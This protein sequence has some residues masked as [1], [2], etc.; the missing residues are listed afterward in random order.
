MMAE[1][2]AQLD[3]ETYANL[4]NYV[5]D[6]ARVKNLWDSEE[7]MPYFFAFT[8]VSTIGYGNVAPVT[9]GGQ[10]FTILLLLSCIGIAGFSSTPSPPPSWRC[11]SG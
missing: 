9:K 2:K 5:D 1:V 6:P 4:V 10:I 7:N 11:R 8:I 3:N